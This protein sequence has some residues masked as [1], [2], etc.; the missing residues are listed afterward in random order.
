MYCILVADYLINYGL[1]YIIIETEPNPPIG[2]LQFFNSTASPSHHSSM[3]FAYD[4]GLGSSLHVLLRLLYAE[5]PH[6]SIQLDHSFHGVQLS[7]KLKEKCT[8]ALKPNKYLSAVDIC[9]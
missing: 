4:E 3:F 9:V 6:F 2:L 7:D 5:I 8:M 1:S